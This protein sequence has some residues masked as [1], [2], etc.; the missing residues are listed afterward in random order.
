MTMFMTSFKGPKWVKM[1]IFFV[2][3]KMGLKLAK[4]LRKSPNNI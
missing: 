3:K 4:K 2:Y 1:E